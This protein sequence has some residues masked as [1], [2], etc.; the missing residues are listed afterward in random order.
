MNSE[1]AGFLALVTALAAVNVVQAV[2]LAYVALRRPRAAAPPRPAQV[3]LAAAGRSGG[4]ATEPRPADRDLMT[5]SDVRAALGIGPR[6]L[7]ALVRAGL[8]A[9]TAPLVGQE[10]RF[11]ASQ[12][13]LLQAASAKTRDGGEVSP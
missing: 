7:S 10:A 2:A 13:R 6:D 8:L 5:A 4:F 3:A 11:S 1:T 12:V 9:R